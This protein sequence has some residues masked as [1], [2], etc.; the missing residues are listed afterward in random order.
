MPFSTRIIDAILTK[1][2]LVV[3]LPLLSNPATAESSNITHEEQRNFLTIGVGRISSDYFGNESDTIGSTHKAYSFAHQLSDQW[4]LEVSHQSEK[5]NESWLVRD[6]AVINVNDTAEIES[7][8]IGLAAAW[9]GEEFGLSMRFSK[10]D[11]TENAEFFLPHIQDSLASDEEVVSLS[12]DQTIDFGDILGKN[13]W[14]FDWSI[15]FQYAKFDLTIDERIFTDPIIDI[16]NKL[17]QSSTS[18]YTDVGLSYWI[19]HQSFAWTPHI[20]LSWNWEI[21]NSGE[22]LVIVSRGDQQIVLDDPGVRFS[23]SYRTP[24][25]GA[26]DLGIDFAWESGINTNIGYGRDI[27]SEFESEKIY[28]DITVAF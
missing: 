19:G 14:S 10:G 7:K 13:I 5:G 23:N 17:S 4:L 12:Y 18:G 21:S 15:G 8:S 26:I 20:S 11:S 22:E 3:L 2:V 6:G 1:L 9:Q 24:N 25:S 27:D 16:N 28:V